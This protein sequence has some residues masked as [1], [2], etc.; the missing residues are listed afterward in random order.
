[1]FVDVEGGK[2]TGGESIF[3]PVFEG[4]MLKKK[5]FIFM[6]TSKSQARPGVLAGAHG[7]GYSGMWV[8]HYMPPLAG[9][10]NEQKSLVCPNEIKHDPSFSKIG[11]SVRASSLFRVKRAA[12]G[13]VSLRLSTSRVPLAQDFFR[14]PPNEPC[15][16]YCSSLEFVFSSISDEDFSIAH[17]KRGIVGMANRGRHTNGSQF[18]ITLQPAPWMDTKY[19]AF[20]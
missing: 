19:V 12:R 14:Y 11:F 4:I 2:G 1:M 10:E 7:V 3:G 13:Y 5:F 17:D 6:S 9:P 16:I 18:F 8:S 15:F 20:G